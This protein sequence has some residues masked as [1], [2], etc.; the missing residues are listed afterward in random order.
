MVLTKGIFS[1]L[2]WRFSCII[3]AKRCGVFFLGRYGHGK[4]PSYDDKT[5][6]K[7][8]PICYHYVS[9]LSCYKY[10]VTGMSSRTTKGWDYKN[11]ARDSH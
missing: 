7:S 4:F 5:C 11:W 3:N 6:L 2:R 1:K 8:L 10:L 9:V